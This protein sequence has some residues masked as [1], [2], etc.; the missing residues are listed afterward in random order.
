M[1]RSYRISLLLALLFCG[2][3]ITYYLRQTP[4]STSQP[5]VS[6]MAQLLEQAQPFTSMAT[7][8]ARIPEPSRVLDEQHE[9]MALT[10]ASTDQLYRSPLPNQA[11]AS[12][13]NPSLSPSQ[14]DQQSTMAGPIV[15]DPLRHPPPPT[16]TLDGTPIAL[17]STATDISIIKLDKQ[18]TPPNT[19]PYERYTILSGDTF[20]SIAIAL[21]GAETYWVDIAQANPL[22]DPTRLKVGQTIRLP[23]MDQIQRAA[24]EPV[25]RAPG[26]T[27]THV[28]RPGDSLS[29]IAQRYYSDSELWRVIFNTNRDVIGS[30]P[31]RLKAGVTLIIPPAPQGAY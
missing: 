6:A 30:K 24:T 7:H 8:D 27:F 13:Q 14:P 2:T 20:S 18:A 4:I 15:D 26:N 11:N 22:I 31:E 21:Y 9:T 19:E 29:T 25:P 28:V 1:N 3:V 12:R 5:R 23:G 16:I 17:A 10:G